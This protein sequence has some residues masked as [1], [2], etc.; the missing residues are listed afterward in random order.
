MATLPRLRRR[1][2]HQA[3]VDRPDAITGNFELHYEDVIH[4]NRAFIITFI[5]TGLLAIAAF[6]PAAVYKSTADSQRV[7]IEVESGK[8]TNPTQITII[9]G[10]PEAGGGGYI[11]FGLPKCLPGQSPVITSCVTK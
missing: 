7:I 4:R 10:D 1:N 3:H 11:E 6:V 5:A 2:K 9:K 8:I